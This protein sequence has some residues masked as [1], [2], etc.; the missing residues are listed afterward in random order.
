VRKGTPLE[1]LAKKLGPELAG[2][3]DTRK[4]LTAAVEVLFAPY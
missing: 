1:E 4:E 2:V 3:A